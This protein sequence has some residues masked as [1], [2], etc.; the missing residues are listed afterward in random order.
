MGPQSVWIENEVSILHALHTQK[1]R[2][3]LHTNVNI[4]KACTSKFLYYLLY[5]FETC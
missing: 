5:S 4:Y 3:W 1:E 2:Y